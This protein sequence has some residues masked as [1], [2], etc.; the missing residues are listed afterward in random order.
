MSAHPLPD[1]RCLHRREEDLG[2]AVD[3]HLP[4]Q[5]RIDRVL[6]MRLAGPR[7]LVDRL[8]P[9][10]G[11]QPAHPMTACDDI[12]PAQIGRD[13]TAAEERVFG[14][15]HHPPLP[16]APFAPEMQHISD[17]EVLE[18]QREPRADNGFLPWHEGEHRGNIW[19]GASALLALSVWMRGYRRARRFAGLRVDFVGCSIPVSGLGDTTIPR[20]LSPNVSALLSKG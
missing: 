5:I 10:L 9:H 1:R 4:Q 18:A 12:V 20:L 8:Q 16:A 7:T 2:R 14:E 11:H 17:S 15:H 6:R 19:G 13:L 3:L